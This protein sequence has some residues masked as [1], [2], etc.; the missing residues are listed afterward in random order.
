MA[1]KLAA[2]KKLKTESQIDSDVTN[3]EEVIDGQ[4]TECADNNES[5]LSNSIASP[6]QGLDM[7]KQKM[8]IGGGILGAIIICIALWFGIKGCSNDNIDI[9]LL[10]AQPAYWNKFVSPKSTSASIYGQPDIS[11]VILKTDQSSILPVLDETENFY[12]VYIGEGREGWVKKNQWKDVVFEPIKKEHLYDFY[13]KGQR[14][15][16]TMQSV[17]DGLLKGLF[18]FYYRDFS[19]AEYLEV[20]ILLNGR[21]IMPQ[22]HRF[23]AITLDKR[24]FNV[25]ASTDGGNPKIEFG[26]NYQVKDGE[27]VNFPNLSELS[28]KQITEIWKV[29][30]GDNPNMVTVAYYF[31]GQK[32]IRCYDIDLNIYGVANKSSKVNVV[33]GDAGL[34]DFTYQ[35]EGQYD[36][37]LEKEMYSL[38][39][40]TSSGEKVSTNTSEPAVALNIL[41]QGD[42][43]GD[44]IPE[45]IVYEWGGGTFIQ[46]PYIVYYDKDEN[47][48][49][50]VEGFD[51]SYSEEEFKIEEWKGQT[52]LVATIGLR[53][54]RW[55]YSNHSLTLVERVVPD[56]GNR[57]ATISLDRLFNVDDDASN[58][59]DNEIDRLTEGLSTLY[60]LQDNGNQGSRSKA[61][62]ATMNLGVEYTP[63]FY[64][65]L[66]FGLMNSTRMAGKYS[67]TD[68]R[69]SANVSPC[70]VLSATANMA[71]GTYGASFGWLLDLHTSGFS[72]F[73]GM[74]H[75]LGKLAKQGLPLSGRGH[76]SVGINI[77]FGK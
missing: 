68:F 12:K 18:L 15:N 66:S 72:M 2:K 46:P 63:D 23:E 73:L 62:A 42:F 6:L 53:K 3:N 39:V 52:T 67:W 49:Q 4:T 14:L 38:Y 44:E 7:D 19:Q 74:D 5:S 21:L 58:S 77:P 60:E 30:Q 40:L 64:D 47:V 20:G 50:R 61:L 13:L 65:K 22:N 29:A 27:G 69:L 55:S 45:A 75:T 48:F 28:D 59:F 56:V 16:S 25:A 71:L 1:G 41:A 70:K 36:T 10:Q 17:N 24:G 33:E 54:D 8:Y 76:V 26:T 35:T 9:Q 31:P 37:A 11:Q 34:S 43:D 57:V 32:T 51:D